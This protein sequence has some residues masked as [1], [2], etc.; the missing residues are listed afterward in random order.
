[1]S[2]LLSTTSLLRPPIPTWLENTCQ[3]LVENEPSFQTVDLT[4]PRIDDVYAKI[5][6]NAL[7][8]NHVV[9][10]LILSCYAIVDDGAYAIGSVLSRNQSIAK[11]QLKDLR[12]SR[13]IITFFQLL[14]RNVTL[15]ELSL[16]HCLICPQGAAAIA[17]FLS[18]HPRIE[19]LRLT[20]TQFTGKNSLC[21]ICQAMK[22][23][24]SLQ[25][26]YFVNNELV[27]AE[28]AHSL[29][30]MLQG[31]SL[32]ELYLVENDLGDDGVAVLTQGILQGNT[33]L[34]HL[35]LRSNGISATGALSLQGLL[36]NSEYLLGLNVSNN[37]LGDLGSQAL[38]R[39]LSQTTCLVQKLDIS[40][41]QV[42]EEGAR[43]MASM[44]RIN[45]TLRELN[46]SFN[47]VGDEGTKLMAAALLRNVSLRRL[48]LRRNDITDKGAKFLASKLP[49]MQ[50]LKELVLSKNNI[51]HDGASALLQGLRSNVELEYLN[52]EE[53]KLWEPISREIIHWIRLNKAGRRI[54][55]TPNTVPGPLWPHLYGKISCDS[56]VVREERELRLLYRLLKYAFSSSDNL[57]VFASSLALLLFNRKAGE[58]PS[59]EGTAA[60]RWRFV[61][62][63]SQSPAKRGNSVVAKKE[64]AQ[65]GRYLLLVVYEKKHTNNV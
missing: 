5:F 54:F 11:L 27:G 50:G 43:A 39:G 7:D 41:N 61:C 59:H 60:G 19:E 44:L 49:A 26:A 65:R 23:N 38:A 48:S 28:S 13:E 52:V 56:N 42:D 51:G 55:R 64:E 53:N 12:N 17:S 63:S 47:F 31:S 18:K 33:A 40:S 6:A 30:E 37:E 46:I 3:K 35:D 29:A 36:V 25:R 10:I 16:R 4:H 62:L 8:E 2:L 9:N 15:T 24:T 22:N 21:V 57:I 32:R 1:M 20:D 14:E 34:R 45:K 58:P